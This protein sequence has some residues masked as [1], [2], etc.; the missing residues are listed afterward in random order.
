M[1]G[2]CTYGSGEWG[3]VVRQWMDAGRGWW[4]LFTSGGVAVWSWAPSVTS[5]GCRG[6][7]SWAVQVVCGFVSGGWSFVVGW[8]LAMCGC[9][10]S[11]V[12]GGCHSSWAPFVV[13]GMGDSGVVDG[14]WSSTC[15]DD[16]G[17]GWAARR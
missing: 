16:G 13:P 11:C 5:A 15:V 12:G 8:L 1:G 3:V 7:R 14:G 4:S 10:R 6:L 9:R 2:A 17:G